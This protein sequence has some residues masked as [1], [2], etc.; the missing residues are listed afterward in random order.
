[1]L[2]ETLS[3]PLVFMWMIVGGIFAGLFFDLKNICLFFLKKKEIKKHFFI[4]FSC[5]F[6]FF[7]FF[8]INLKVNYGEIRFFTIVTFALSFAIER[9]IIKNFIAK[10]VE[11]CYNKLKEKQNA[12]RKEREQKKI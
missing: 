11:R 8:L 9:F 5:F 1:M 10:R 3:Q 7:L 2:Y 12:K 4:F 6:T